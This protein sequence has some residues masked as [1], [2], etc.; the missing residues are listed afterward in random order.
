VIDQVVEET[1]NVNEDIVSD[2]TAIRFLNRVQ[3]LK[4]KGEIQL[5]EAQRI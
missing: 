3:Y 5:F 4:H 2:W 1:P